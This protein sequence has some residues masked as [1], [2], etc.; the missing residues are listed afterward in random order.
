MLIELKKTT[1]LCFYGLVANCTL[2]VQFIVFVPY[3]FYF[4]ENAGNYIIFMEELIIC[5]TSFFT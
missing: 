3:S 4:Y 5:Y 1:P 2:A